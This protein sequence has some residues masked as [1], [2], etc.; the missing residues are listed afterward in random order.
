MP[1]RHPS[2]RVVGAHLGSLEYDLDELASRLDAYDNFAVDTSARFRDLVSHGGKRLRDFFLTYDDRILFGTDVVARRPH[3][4]MA[5]VEREELYEKVRKD[6]LAQ[7]AYFAGNQPVT[8]GDEVH[9]GIELPDDV[10]R[11]FFRENARSWH[12]G[13]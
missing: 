10:L 5:G 8:F 6:Y 9:D 2:L 12:P 3:S 11:E 7:H 13:M 4:E 1:A